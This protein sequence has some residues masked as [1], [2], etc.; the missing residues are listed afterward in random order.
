MIVTLI[1]PYYF[2]SVR[3]NSITVQRIASGLRDQGVEVEV[4][5]LD[6]HDRE[7][8]RGALR[9]SRPDIVHGFHATASGS[10]V[11]EATRTLGIPSVITL[12]GTDVN[13]DL[14]DSQRCALVREPLCAARAIVVFHEA[15]GEKVRHKLPDVAGKLRVIG[16]AVLCEGSSGYDLR[17]TLGLHPGD[18]VFL[19]PAGVRRIKNIPTVIPWLATLQRH[20]PTLKYVLAGPVIEPHEAERVT[21]MLDGLSWAT[22]LGAVAHEQICASLS[23]VQVVINSSLSEGGMSNAVLEA[24][25]KGVAVL[26]SDIEGN[27][28]VIVDG[29]DGFLFASADEFLAKAERLLGDPALRTVMGR[30]AQRKATAHFRLEGEID[31]YL[32][33]YR[34]LVSSGGA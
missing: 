19:H 29:E 18:F 11:A 24:M 13:Q 17:A 31:Q 16:Q 7:A 26:A 34:E 28:S 8:I 9:L 30:R 1:T 23:A 2:P 32:A 14:F 10:L 15:I 4:L 27:R 22:F 6:R 20:H 12:T 21:H 3:G 33:L 25:S 5:S